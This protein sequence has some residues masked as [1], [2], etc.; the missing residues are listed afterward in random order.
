[1][2]FGPASR[3]WTR[4]SRS[5]RFGVALMMGVAACTVIAVP[6]GA[7]VQL[8]W[9]EPLLV[10]R[11]AALAPFPLGLQGVSCPSVTLCVAVDFLG[12]VVTS[13]DPGADRGWTVARLRGAPDLTSVACPSVSLCVA[14]DGFGSVLSSTNPAGGPRAWRSAVVNARGL[15]SLTGVSCPSVSLCVATD[16]FRGDVFTTTNPSGGARAWTRA[17]VDPADK[18][19]AFLPGPARLTGVSCPSVSLCVA[20]DDHGRVL[21]STNPTGGAGAWRRVHVDPAAGEGLSAVSCASV[22]LCVAIDSSALSSINPAGGR[23]AWHAALVFPV[24]LV[25]CP[26][27]SFCALGAL[28]GG[29]LTSTNPTGGTGAW[30]HV[31][32]MDGTN[33]LQGMSCPSVSLCVGVD[34]AGNVVLGAP[35]VL[36]L[37]VPRIVATRASPLFGFNLLARRHRRRLRVDPGLAVVCPPAG[38][39]CT[40]T[41]TASEAD[42]LPT[43]SVRIARFRVKVRAGTTRKLTFDL[44]TRGARLLIHHRDFPDA[45]LNVI[46]QAGHGYEVAND[47]SFSLAAPPAHPTH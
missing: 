35:T 45:T 23:S 14:V 17:H 5:V 19:K 36:G 6:A 40:V 28:D 42:T 10:D 37:G 15:G 27:V 22:T 34:S 1:M 31:R 9:S 20:V 47:L 39:A 7:S 16:A 32:V 8:S 33:G 11:A 21:S 30:S 46:A 13:T 24:G 12:N 41:G 2:R 25:S 26:F 44:S 29:L 38:P 43:G 4:A 3:R 18:S